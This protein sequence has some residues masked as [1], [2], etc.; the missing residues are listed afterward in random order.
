MG[1]QEHD[2]LRVLWLLQ[3]KNKF[4]NYEDDKRVSNDLAIYTYEQAIIMFFASINPKLY[5]T[6]LVDLLKL[7]YEEVLEIAKT[8]DVLASTY[9]KLNLLNSMSLENY[10][11]YASIY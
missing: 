1:A 11:I 4:D 6:E 2:R 9:A 10:D 7:T 3:Q 8:N 5:P